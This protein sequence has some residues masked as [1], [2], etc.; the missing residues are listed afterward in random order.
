MDLKIVCYGDPV[1]R[2]KG[3][4]IDPI[5]PEIHRLVDAMFD[6]MGRAN[7]IGLAAQQVG[8]A[9][10]LAIIDVREVKNR[11]SELWVDE[12]PTDVESFMPLTLI[13]PRIEP[14]GERVLGPEGCLSFPGIY[15]EITRP[16]QVSV[17]ALNREGKP[18]A[19][20]AAGLLARAIQH[21]V[22]HLNGILFIDRMDRATLDEVR[23][24]V[25]DLMAK[26]RAE[27]ARKTTDS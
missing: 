9:L 12:Q 2:R 19:F 3:V 7:G 27:L 23:E 6:T 8:H 26:T 21:E 10:Q 5:T 1:L 17:Q 20:R 13:N 22:D 4:L 18:I 16:D 15:A 24:D 25:E 14:S 11:P